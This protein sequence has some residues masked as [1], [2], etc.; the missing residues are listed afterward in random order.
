[1]K[2]RILWMLPV[3]GVAACWPRA[4]SQRRSPGRR[5]RTSPSAN[6]KSAGYAPANMLSPE[7][8][9]TIVAQ[10][11]TKVENPT[12]AISLLRLRQRRPERPRACRRWSRRRRRRPRRRRPSRT[13]TRTSCFKG[14]A[15]RRRR[16][17][18]T[19]RTSS[20]RATRAARARRRH[21]AH[22]PR[23]R[24][25]AP[26]DGARDD[27]TRP[28]RRSRTSTARRGIRGHSGCCSRR[29]TRPRRP[30]PRRRTIRR[31]STDVSGALGRGG[32]EG[33]QDDSAG[34]IWIVE[35][36]GG[37]K[38]AGHDREAAEQLPLPLRARRTPGDL[39][40]RKLE[41]LQV[42]NAGR[43]TPITFESQ[44]ALNAP[45]RSRC[46]RTAR[47]STRSGSSSTTPPSTARRRST[48]TR[49]PRRRT[50]RRSSGPRTGSSVRARSSRE[51]YFDETGDT[52]ATSPENDTAGGWGSVLKLTQRRPRA[53]TGTLHALLQG[54]RG[55]RGLRQRDVP[56]ARRDHV[57]A[58]RGRHPAH[59]AKRSTRASS[60]TCEATTPSRATSRSAGS[61]RA[62]IRRRPSTPRTGLRKNDGDNE[63]TG[64]HV[65]DGDPAQDGILGAKIP[66]L[67]DKRRGAGSGRSSTATTSPGRCSRANADSKHGDR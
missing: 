7:L 33:I 9:Q 62:A 17:T 23:R 63:I 3:V 15:R 39:A 35:D 37:A 65:S 31:R 16:A 12:A 1:M 26:R 4:A 2:R 8:Q 53:D 38:K 6:T 49:R 14:A 47:R 13:R 36:I 66:N 34:N 59:R 54:E 11:S 25:R 18:T 45:T 27:R 55:D 52:N 64:V 29:R 42:M 48:P 61:P 67:A 22:Q 5:S 30:T 58:G 19:A 51:F 41:A 28:V 46:T 60:S 32:Y 56:L 21:H 40:E 10:G 43:R 24:R 20:S 44:A 57:R 50:P